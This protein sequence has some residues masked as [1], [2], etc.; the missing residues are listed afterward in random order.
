[1][2]EKGGLDLLCLS[3][4]TSDVAWAARHARHHE[5][6]VLTR[7]DPMLTLRWPYA[8]PML[9]LCVPYVDPLLTHD[10]YQEGQGVSAKEG[11]RSS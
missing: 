9:T 4:N 3:L 5:S 11:A 8:G 2:L 1:M 10:R 7:A 6:H